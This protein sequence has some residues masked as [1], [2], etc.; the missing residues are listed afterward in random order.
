MFEYDATAILDK[1]RIPTL[2]IGAR[3]DRLTKMEA[4]HVMNKKI[5]GSRL[6]TLSLAGHMGFVERHQ[7]VNEGVNAFLKH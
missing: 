1:I 3:F 2:V 7:E 4:S 6:L 5:Q